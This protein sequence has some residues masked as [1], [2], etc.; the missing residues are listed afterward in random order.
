M[1]ATGV[2]RLVSGILGRKSKH[3]LKDQSIRNNNECN[4]HKTEAIGTE[5]PYQILTVMSAQDNLSTPI[6]S[7]YECGMTV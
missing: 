6:C 4:I 5:K 1:R 2:E 3:T 7:Q